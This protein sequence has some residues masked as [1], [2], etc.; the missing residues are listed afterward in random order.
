[1][2]FLSKYSGNLRNIRWGAEQRLEFIE[3]KLYWEGKLNRGDLRNFFGIS[4]PQASADIG[5][6]IEIAPLNID[7]DKSSKCYFATPNFKPMLITPDAEQ[8]LS[9]FCSSPEI[10]QRKDSIVAV[11]ILKLPERRIESEVLRKVIKAIKFGKALQIEYQSM[12]RPESTSRWITPHALGFDGLR[13]HVRSFCH[14]DI[15]FK[16]FL[17]GRIISIKGEK[18]HRVDVSLD[19]EWHQF[20]YIKI[21]PHP[22]LTR[23]Q[24]EIIERDY[25]MNDG[26]VTIH[27]RAALVFYLIRQL[28]LEEGDMERPPKSQQ[29]VLLN[30]SEVKEAI[31]SFNQGTQSRLIG[32]IE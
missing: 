1:M 23:G 10:T 4:N 15:K 12:S 17:L 8:Y 21:G 25:G 3:F 2:K 18:H 14:N 22:G 9:Q 7:Y 19:E 13:W 28:R 27:V 31:D 16:D 32:D 30:R 26:M 24:K 6:Y 29:I 20:V 5:K 11:D